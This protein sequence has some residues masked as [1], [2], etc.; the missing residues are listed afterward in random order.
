MESNGKTFTSFFRHLEATRCISLAVG[1]VCVSVGTVNTYKSVVGFAGQIPLIALGIGL[2]VAICEASAVEFA[3]QTKGLVRAGFIALF[4]A[5][6][7]YIITNTLFVYYRAYNE[8]KIEREARNA[9]AISDNSIEMRRYKSEVEKYNTQK[10]SLE[11]EIVLIDETIGGIPADYV[12]RRQEL[13]KRREDAMQKLNALIVP[14]EPET[15]SMTTEHTAWELIAG[16]FG[17]D[18]DALSMIFLALPAVIADIASPLFFCMFFG[19]KTVI[20][21][22]KITRE[23]KKREEKPELNEIFDYIDIAMKNDFSMMGDELVGKINPARCKKLREYIMSFIYKGKPVISKHDGKY[24]S[25]FN[26]ENLK[27]FVE[28]QH[29]TQRVNKEWN[30]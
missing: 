28:L 3:K 18:A 14:I 16:I 17:W 7:F 9:D 11:T 8:Q 19:Q 12:T 5:S 25:I 30:R 20:P 10:K 15:S 4:V 2:T 26:K 1:L 13:L 27:R 24:F 6:M 29:E 21:A 23:N 22:K